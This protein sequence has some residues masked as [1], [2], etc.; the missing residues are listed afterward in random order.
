MSKVV[1]VVD[2]IV[3]VT[4]WEDPEFEGAEHEPVIAAVYEDHGDG[5]IDGCPLASYQFVSARVASAIL[6][7][8][9]P[10]E[11]ARI[12]VWLEASEG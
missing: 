8:L 6:G 3:L 7:G 1:P 10:A 11:Q 2:V 4:H 5:T 12:I 9:T